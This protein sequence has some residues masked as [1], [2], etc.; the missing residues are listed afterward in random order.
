MRFHTLDKF[1]NKIDLIVRKYSFLMTNAVYK[2]HSW[3]VSFGID[4]NNTNLLH[5]SN[6]DARKEHKYEWLSE[7]KDTGTDTNGMV[8]D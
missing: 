1:S 5:S 7:K 2:L 6:T 8:S 3:F 4:R